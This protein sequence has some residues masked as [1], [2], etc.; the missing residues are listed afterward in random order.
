M[1]TAYRYRFGLIISGLSFG[2][3]GDVIDQFAL[4]LL[5]DLM[6]QEEKADIEGTDGVDLTSS[7]V[8]LALFCGVLEGDN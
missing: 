3:T 8:N 5:I 1:V 6:D 2:L 7:C 4:H